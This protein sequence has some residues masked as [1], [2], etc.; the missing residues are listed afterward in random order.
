[1]AIF[2]KMIFFY[3]PNDSL[4]ITNKSIISFL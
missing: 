3:L 1:M 4:R 2:E